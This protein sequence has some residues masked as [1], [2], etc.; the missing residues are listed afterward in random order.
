MQTEV[1]AGANNHQTYM[2]FKYMPDGTIKYLSAHGADEVGYVDMEQASEYTSKEQIAA[3]SPDAG[4][5]P[6]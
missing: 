1:L 5:Y 2:G 6:L 4:T 3:V